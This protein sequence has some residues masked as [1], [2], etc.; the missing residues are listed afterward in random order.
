M[1][2]NL[3]VSAR[4]PVAVL[5]F[6]YSP[7]ILGV[8][9]RFVRWSL[10]V[11]QVLSTLRNNGDRYKTPKYPLEYAMQLQVIH[12]QQQPVKTGEAVTQKC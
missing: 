11:I 1:H 10:Q 8:N 9:L 6:V 2:I 7:W 4:V 5:S 3:E 12:K